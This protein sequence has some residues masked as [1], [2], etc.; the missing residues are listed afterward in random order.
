M[1]FSLSDFFS[2]AGAMEKYPSSLI[3]M[4]VCYI[5]AGR[6]IFSSFAFRFSA[7]SSSWMMFC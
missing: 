7:S 5:I 2:M 3:Y 1:F 4:V 6:G